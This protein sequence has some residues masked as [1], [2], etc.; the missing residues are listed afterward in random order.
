[1]NIQKLIPH[2][3]A[4][5]RGHLSEHRYGQFAVSASR[6]TRHRLG[7]YRAARPRRAG[8]RCCGGR[9]RKP[10]GCAHPSSAGQRPLELS[11]TPP[12]PGRYEYA[13]EAWTDV[14]AAA[15]RYS[16]QCAGAGSTSAWN[17][18]GPNL[19]CLKPHRRRTLARRSGEPTQRPAR[20]T[21]ADDVAAAATKA[22]N[23]PDPQPGH[24]AGVIGRRPARSARLNGAAQPEQRSGRHGSGGLH[25][26]LPDIASLGF[27]VVCLTP[28]IDRPPPR[29]GRNN[30]H[31]ETGRQAASMPSARKTAA[32]RGPS[33]RH[34][35]IFPF[36]RRLPTVGWVALNTRCNAPD[37]RVAAHPDSSSAGPMA[38]SI[39]RKSTEEIPGHRQ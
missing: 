26:A 9:K 1:M 30:A 7:R 24:A 11:F 22:T 15:P 27:D 29:K 25:R 17:P 31:G 21:V 39:R 23:R 4:Y 20:N 34:S 6:A 12:K 10:S 36:C 14:S 35:P 32:R 13:I 28:S 18:R 5:P 33:A 16:R 2:R 3:A 37:P 8:G 19:A 38:H